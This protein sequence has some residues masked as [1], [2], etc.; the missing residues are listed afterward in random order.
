MTWINK[1][2]FNRN[3]RNETPNKELAEELAD[4]NNKKGIKEISEYLYDKN[5][6]ISSDCLSV[7][8]TIGYSKPE[9]IQEY[10]DD[11]LKL[12]E[13]KI[14][15]MVWGSMIAISTIVHL[16]SANI[17]RNI[18]LILKTMREGT[19]I[20]EVWG[21]KTLVNLSI[22]NKEYKIKLIPVLFDYLEKC[23]P[24][25]FATRI[26]TIMPVIASSEENEI[27]DRIIEIK[28]TEL[29]DSQIKKLR[30]VLKKTRR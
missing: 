19:L 8:Y 14:N 26:E 21:I 3:I 7:L 25:D 23:R 12:L 15:R 2:A 18:D 30:T 10:I 11:F 24:I 1:I 28:I 9:L 20:T 5:K 16:K 22:E 6:S 4:T 13:S 29:S 27:L 17:F